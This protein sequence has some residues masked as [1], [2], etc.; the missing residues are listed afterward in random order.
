MRDRE[1]IEREAFIA[2][3]GQIL[4]E[5]LPD[6]YDADDFESDAGE[7][8]DWVEQHAWEPFV[9]M[10]A[11]QLW[12]EIDCLAGTLLGFKERF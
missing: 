9:G 8:D 2:A 10:T 6:N 4:C 7:I 3:S 5:Y 1:G 11:K 12:K